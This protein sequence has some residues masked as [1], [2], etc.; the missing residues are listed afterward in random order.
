MWKKYYK[1]HWSTFTLVALGILVGLEL[2][3]ERM[4][5]IPVGNIT[6]FSL[7]KICV[8]M[9]GMWFGPVA[10]ALVGLVADLLGCLMQGYA[11]VPLI[12]LSSILWGSVPALFKPWV[13]KSSGKIMKVVFFSIGIIFAASVC[14]LVVTPIGLHQYYGYA[15]AAIMPARFVQFAV[16]APTYC[17]LCSLLY[18]SPVTKTVASLVFNNAKQSA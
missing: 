17:V 13:M 8:V 11:I 7:G 16:M 14:L 9:A 6:R 1:T 12:T 18:L 15:F 2:V 4:L 5:A 10:G 3:F